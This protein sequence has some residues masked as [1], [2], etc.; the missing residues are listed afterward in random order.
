MHLLLEKESGLCPKPASS[1]D[2]SFP[3]SVFF[4]LVTTW[5]F[6]LERM[7]VKEFE[8]SLH[9]TKKERTKKGFVFQVLQSLALLM[10]LKACLSELDQLAKIVESK[11]CF[12][13]SHVQMR[14]LDHKEDCAPKNWWFWTAVL[15]KT[16]KSSLDTKEIKP[17][18]PR[19]N[20]PWK[21]IRIWSWSS[22][23][24]V[25]WCKEP[26]HGKRPWC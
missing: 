6:P 4:P 10:T 1:F 14:E 13:S 12:S 25:V 11:L 2:C 9:S 19:G 26:I 21:F 17:V 3:A 15:E 24:L 16:F 5:I 8:W 20:K 22:H 23:T 18:N 7:K